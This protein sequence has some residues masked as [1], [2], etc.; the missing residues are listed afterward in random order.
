[1]VIIDVKEELANVDAMTKPDYPNRK[2]FWEVKHRIPKSMRAK[3]KWCYNCGKQGEYGNKP[4]IRC[5]CVNF[6]KTKPR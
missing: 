5:G 1:M 3:K 2:P 4:C 6:R